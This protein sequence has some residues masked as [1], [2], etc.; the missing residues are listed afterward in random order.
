MERLPCQPRHDGP[1]VDTIPQQWVTQ[2]GHVHPDLVGAPGMQHAMHQAALRDLSEQVSIGL[3]G[4]SW[5]GGQIDDR[6]AQAV[7]RVAAYGRFDALLGC[8]APS[9]FGQGQILAVHAARG[10][11]LYQGVHSL[12]GARHHHQAAG[13]FIQPMH[14]ARARHGGQ[15]GVHSQQA[16]E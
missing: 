8:T 14:N 4:F 9:A 2:G 13:I 15:A 7:A 5:R 16:V 6:H 3:R 1:T 12:A 11:R 10:D